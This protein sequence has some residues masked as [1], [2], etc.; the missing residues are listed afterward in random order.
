MSF[1]LRLLCLF[2]A[3]GFWNPGCPSAFSA[4]APATDLAKILDNMGGI[5]FNGLPNLSFDIV[6]RS[7]ASELAALGFGFRL[8]H[9]TVLRHGR[10]AASRWN[11]SGLHTCAYTDTQGDIVWLTTSGQTVRFRKGEHGYASSNNNAT[12]TVSPD[13]S[14]IEITTQASVKWRYRDG[15]LESITS[16]RGSYAVT[17]DRETILSISKK[18]LNRELPLM[19]CTYSKQGNLNELEFSGGKKYRLQWSADHTLTAIDDPNG[20]RFDFEYANSL[21]SCWTQAN[22]PRNEL[23]WRHLDYIR[24]TAFQIPPVL[25]REDAAHSYAYE[26]DKWGGVERVTIHDKTGALVSDTKIR[27]SLV[28]QITPDGKNAR[29]FRRSP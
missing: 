11:L 25:L 22:G 20:R 14:L 3:I 28:E 21:L 29:V 2:A 13:G 19:K 5:G 10:T 8:T 26:L 18:I 7:D 17:T 12:V 1:S 27:A 6:E 4:P 9:Q 23:K 16:G 15:F 24:E